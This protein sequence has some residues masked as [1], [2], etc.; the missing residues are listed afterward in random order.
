MRAGLVEVGELLF[1]TAAADIA[2]VDLR[3]DA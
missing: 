2:P 1:F 3:R